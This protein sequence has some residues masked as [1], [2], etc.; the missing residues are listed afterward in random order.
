MIMDHEFPLIAAA[1][2]LWAAAY[3][4]AGAQAACGAAQAAVIA[5]RTRDAFRAIAVEVL[6][7]ADETPF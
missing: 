1:D 7:L 5:A 6:D 2:E 4:V 3:V